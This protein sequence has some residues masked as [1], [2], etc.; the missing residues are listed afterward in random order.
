MPYNASKQ[1]QN[2]IFP[3]LISLYQTENNSNAIF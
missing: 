2:D 3:K 1:D